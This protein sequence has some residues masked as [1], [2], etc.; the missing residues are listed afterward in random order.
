MKRSKT[1][2]ELEDLDELL[3]LGLKESEFSFKNISGG[4]GFSVSPHLEIYDI[5]SGNVFC[6]E[7]FGETGFA[8]KGRIEAFAE[9]RLE[10]FL[11]GYEE[12]N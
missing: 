9:T 12:K 7:Y 4:L 11:M 6:G 8:R 3:S 10:I 1:V 2:Y 5:Q